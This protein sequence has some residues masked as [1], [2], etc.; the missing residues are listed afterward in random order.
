MSDEQLSDFDVFQEALKSEEFRRRFTE[1]DQLESQYEIESL[2]PAVGQ[3]YTY[4]QANGDEMT[5][6]DM[7]RQTLREALVKSGFHDE[8]M[9]EFAVAP[10]FELGDVLSRARTL[11]AQPEH[12]DAKIADEV[13]AMI[14][15]FK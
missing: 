7:Q 10:S 8:Q 1:V 14:R 9:Q 11:A 6:P 5:I 13:V 12:P 2:C 3:R 4:T 15:R